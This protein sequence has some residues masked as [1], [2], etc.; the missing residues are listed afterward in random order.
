MGK[1]T[2]TIAILIAIL[3]VGFLGFA[4][5]RASD[6]NI[7]SDAPIIAIMFLIPVITGA[8]YYSIKVKYI[9]IRLIILGL[10]FTLIGV[11]GLFYGGFV[12][13]LFYVFIGSGAVLLGTAA[14]LAGDVRGG[15]FNPRIA[16]YMEDIAAEKSRNI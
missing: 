3:F 12:G 13:K 14:W 5:G 16:K 4:L 15:S 8:A 7:Q 6:V 2:G 9:S 11:T 10:T 1:L